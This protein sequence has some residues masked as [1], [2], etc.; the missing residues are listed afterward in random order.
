MADND[1]EVDKQMAIREVTDDLEDG[2]ERVNDLVGPAEVLL[3][4]VNEDSTTT[5]P[6]FIFQGKPDGSYDERSQYFVEKHGLAIV[7]P[8]ITRRWEYKIH[9][10]P[11]LE[12]IIEEYDNHDEVIY[13]VRYTDGTENE[14]SGCAVQ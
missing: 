7:V 6:I 9:E 13:L 1:Q 12:E 8:P 4:E 3:N 14:V 10:E 5:E 11:L 2:L